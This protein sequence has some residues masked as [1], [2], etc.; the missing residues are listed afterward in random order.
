MS[1]EYAV[2]ICQRCIRYVKIQSMSNETIAINATMKITQ[3]QQQQQQNQTYAHN[4]TN[5]HF[6]VLLSIKLYFKWRYSIVSKHQR[7]KKTKQKKK[8]VEMIFK[9]PKNCTLSHF[10]YTKPKFTIKNLVDDGIVFSLLP[11]QYV[12]NVKNFEKKISK[13]K[14]CTH[15]YA[16]IWIRSACVLRND[17]N[18]E[19]VFFS[20]T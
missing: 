5:T 1:T 4:S 9:L 10:Q 8:F 14:T 17:C 20:E 3:S 12:S 15:V 16:N 7:K 19:S 11:F 2:S 6:Y 13:N 18:F